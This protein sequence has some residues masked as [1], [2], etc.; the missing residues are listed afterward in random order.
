MAL[1]LFLQHCLPL[2]REWARV[3][4]GG[5]RAN[6]LH[7]QIQKREVYLVYRFG[8]WYTISIRVVLSRTTLPRNPGK[9]NASFTSG[10]NGGSQSKTSRLESPGTKLDRAA[11][12]SGACRNLF[13]RHYHRTSLLFQ[14]RGKFGNCYNTHTHS[15][16]RTAR[17]EQELLL[18]HVVL[19]QCSGWDFAFSIHTL[20]ALHIWQN[21]Q[22]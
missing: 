1:R 22:K 6:T 5:A 14:L 20:R 19:F 17:A 9:T 21:L 2:I 10:R 15:Q 11:N 12:F 4:S 13:W 16:K 3:K 7:V 18:W 8:A